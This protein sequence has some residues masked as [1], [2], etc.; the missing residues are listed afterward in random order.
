MDATLAK[1]YVH[2][3]P[4]RVKDQGLE[5]RIELPTILA[6]NYFDLDFKLFLCLGKYNHV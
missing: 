1:D 3:N 4:N 6:L 5:Y 2:V